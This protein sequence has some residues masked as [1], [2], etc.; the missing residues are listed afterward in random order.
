MA[1]VASMA[2]RPESGLEAGEQIEA[3]ELEWD[4]AEKLAAELMAQDNE[5]IYYALD[6]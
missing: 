3:T 2:V 5:R 6:S 4:E 1:I